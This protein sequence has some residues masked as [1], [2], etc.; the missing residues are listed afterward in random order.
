[1]PFWGNMPILKSAVMQLV[2]INEC[3]YCEIGNQMFFNV[4][5]SFLKTQEELVMIYINIAK[6]KLFI[7]YTYCH[8]A[9]C[10]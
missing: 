4:M 6:I 9:W 8:F 3:K 7:I 2:F 10:I 1:M 5:F